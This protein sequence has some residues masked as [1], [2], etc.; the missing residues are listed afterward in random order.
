MKKYLPKCCWVRQDGSGRYEVAHT[1]T[2]SRCRHEPT[3]G[4]GGSPDG[5]T[6]CN[7][8]IASGSSR[9]EAIEEA[10][11]YLGLGR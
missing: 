6:R 1:E 7:R 5:H 3:G 2:D 10:R 4:T 11:E 8:I 9:A